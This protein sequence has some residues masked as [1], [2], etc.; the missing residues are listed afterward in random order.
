MVQ[1]TVYQPGK[2][3]KQRP[4]ALRSGHDRWKIPTR[5][6]SPEFGPCAR[7][8]SDADVK[9]NPIASAT[10][11]GRQIPAAIIEHPPSQGFDPKRPNCFC[12]LQRR[13]FHWSTLDN[14]PFVRNVDLTDEPCE[15]QREIELLSH[16]WLWGNQR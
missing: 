10:A 2:V 11:L 8:E 12:V 4:G 1:S 3:H 5:A 14:S 13:S 7:Q 6:C 9:E 15:H 16:L